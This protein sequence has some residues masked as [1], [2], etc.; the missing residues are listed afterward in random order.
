MNFCRLSGCIR[1]FL[2][3][4]ADGFEIF[5]RQPLLPVVRREHHH[6][7]PQPAQVVRT[8]HLAQSVANPRD[9]AQKV[10]QRTQKQEIVQEHRE[11]VPA[12][13]GARREVLRVP[14]VGRRHPALDVPVDQRDEAHEGEKVEV[15]HSREPAGIEVLE[16]V[17]D[18]RKFDVGVVAQLVRD[19]VVRVVPQLPGEQRGRPHDGQCPGHPVV[20]LAALG[21]GP[22]QAGVVRPVVP[23]P[24]ELV[25]PERHRQQPAPL[26]ET[27]GDPGSAREVKPSE[28]ERKAVERLA[29]L[30]E[31][32]RVEQVLGARGGPKLFVEGRGV[33]ELLEGGG[34]GGA[35]GHGFD[36]STTLIGVHPQHHVGRIAHVENFQHLHTAGVFSLPFRGNVDRY[37]LVEDGHRGFRRLTLF[38][39]LVVLDR[40]GCRRVGACIRRFRF[41]LLLQQVGLAVEVD[42]EREVHQDVGVVEEERRPLRV[43]GPEIL[44]E[45]VRDHDAESRHELQQLQVR[46]HLLPGEGPLHDAAGVVVVHHGVDE[47]VEHHVD[48]GPLHLVV[49]PHREVDGRADVVQVLEPDYRAVAQDQKVGVQKLHVLREVEE[50]ANPA[51][52]AGGVVADAV[53]AVRQLGGHDVDHVDAGPKTEHGEDQI[54][55][56]HDPLAGLL[57]LFVHVGLLDVRAEQRLTDHVG[58]DE[59]KKR[60]LEVLGKGN[61]V[62]DEG[63]VQKRA[64]VTNAS[65][66]VRGGSSGEEG[67]GGR[68]RREGVRHVAVEIL[69]E[70]ENHAGVIRGL[71]TDPGTDGGS[72]V[73]GRGRGDVTSSGHGS[74]ASG[75]GG[76]VEIAVAVV[77]G[78][79]H[80]VS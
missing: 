43:H 20:H 40:S 69:A 67:A 57:V 27:A 42:E 66:G 75:H 29:K 18:R 14:V 68:S 52:H 31:R 8:K 45:G 76:G 30:V 17:Q 71:G 60:V 16:E 56:T 19:C 34:F 12:G 74:V 11:H 5:D 51:V 62:G 36:E 15:L 4:H 59:E 1:P 35:F 58:K 73:V 77:S 37:P 63:G 61:R 22:R 50:V 3:P 38:R 64:N 70:R 54:V 46:D 23:E 44:V 7:A 78:G 25:P 39:G 49:V 26:L 21:R 10:G 53:D 72:Q 33:L 32:L 79:N 2:L 48:P 24:A 55:H 65:S 28:N 6:P 47:A 9:R 41:V 80:P 13:V